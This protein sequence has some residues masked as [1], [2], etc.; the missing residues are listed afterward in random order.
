LD[1]LFNIAFASTTTSNSAGFAYSAYAGISTRNV[2][3]L[4]SVAS[5]TTQSTYTYGSNN[6]GATYLLTAAN[7]PISVPVATYLTPGEYFIGFNLITTT[8]GNT[9]IGATW[10]VMGQAGAL[11]ASNYNYAEFGTVTLATSGLQGGMGVFGAATTGM[12]ASIALSS[13]TQ[14][15]SSLSQANIALVLRNV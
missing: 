13:I 12:P 6:S 9:N 11:T 4:S 1:A 8:T 14:T 7:R 5:G 2:S 3:T 10:S 15:G